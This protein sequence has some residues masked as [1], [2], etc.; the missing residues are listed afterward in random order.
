MSLF[1]NI[2]ISKTGYV[3]E[4]TLA[5][6]EKRNAFT[7]NMVSE[8]LEAI[9]QFNADNDIR[10]VL[11]KAEGSVFCAGM[12]LKIF[13]NP[14]LEE[15]INGL[16]RTNLPLADVMNTLEKPSIAIVEA[17][18]IAGGFL[19][20]LGCNYIFAKSDVK[21]YL[22]EVKVGI[23]PFQVLAVLM[24]FMPQNKALDLCITARKINAF[25]A[26]NMGIVHHV[27]DHIENDIELNE[28]ILTI[29]NNAPLAIKMGIMAAKQI[30]SVPDNQQQY[31]LG[32]LNQLR[33]SHD[34][35]E[36][37]NALF[38]KRAPIW[39]GN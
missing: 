34:A 39:N 33:S 4:L 25:E 38:E 37:T 36:G 15:P 23:F 16:S 30:I 32:L 18:V 5:R 6:A 28:L 13:Q 29:V 22:P 27:F 7:P 3:G 19:I 2:K 35:K 1:K 8:I 17:D 12:D 9:K 11:V 14:E 24:R 21:F 26:Q 31:L 20:A 10:L